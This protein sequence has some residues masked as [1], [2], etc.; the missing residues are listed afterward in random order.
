MPELR[1]GALTYEDSIRLGKRLQPRR[2]IRRIAHRSDTL[3]RTDAFQIASQDQPRGDP[4]ANR[5]LLWPYR[6]DDRQT[7]VHRT[8]RMRFVRIRPTE[9]RKNSVTDKSGNVAPLCCN[10]A[11]NAR[12]VCGQ[13]FT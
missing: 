13:D 5:K 4:D 7:R 2:Q 11:R 6:V 12:L 10:G 9:I 3:S 8:D 1:A